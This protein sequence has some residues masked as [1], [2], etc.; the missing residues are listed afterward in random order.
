MSFIYSQFEQV[1]FTCV[2][3]C[4]PARAGYHFRMVDILKC[5]HLTLKR[6]RKITTPPSYDG[7]GGGGF[8]EPPLEFLLSYNMSKRF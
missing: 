4:Y 1:V 5:E 2:S 8:K 7:G 6:T 3:L